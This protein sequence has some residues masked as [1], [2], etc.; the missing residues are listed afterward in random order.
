MTATTIRAIACG[1]LLLLSIS[2]AVGGWA[3]VPEFD[4]AIQGGRIFDGTGAPSYLG[5]VGIRGD[6]WPRSHRRRVSAVAS[7][8]PI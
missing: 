4:L 2:F 3:V 1:V 5:D 7:T 8:S 6:R